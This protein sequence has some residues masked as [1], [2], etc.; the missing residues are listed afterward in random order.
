MVAEFSCSSKEHWWHSWLCSSLPLNFSKPDLCKYHKYLHQIS[1]DITCQWRPR[2]F[3]SVSDLHPWCSL[4]AL[5][6]TFF[7]QKTRMPYKTSDTSDQTWLQVPGCCKWPWIRAK[8]C[9]SLDKSSPTS[10]CRCD[11]T[12]CTAI[13]GKKSA[14][15]GTT[16]QGQ[17]QRNQP[18]ATLN[19]IKN[20]IQKHVNDV[21]DVRSH[22]VSLS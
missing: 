2:M 11:I 7:C 6:L 1:I 16:L 13:K 22:I 20:M 14:I 4:L 5:T 18:G 17:N 8:N 21:N 12:A 10:T 9:H 15:K 3:S 19:G